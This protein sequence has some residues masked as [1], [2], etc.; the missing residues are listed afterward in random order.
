MKSI[1]D[2]GLVIEALFKKGC[3]TVILTLGEKGAIFQSSSQ[4]TFTFVPAKRVKAVDSTVSIVIESIY[5][6]EL[7]MYK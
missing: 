4:K 6:Y 7:N 3:S 2:C 1:D 5:I